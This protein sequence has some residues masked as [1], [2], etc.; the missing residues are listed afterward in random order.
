[1]NLHRIEFVGQ[2]RYCLDLTPDGSFVVS[3]RDHNFERRI[4]VN[5]SFCQSVVDKHK[6][7]FADRIRNHLDTMQRNG[8]KALVV[9]R[10]WNA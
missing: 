9:M 8:N 7:V 3:E 6:T 2:H 4:K 1:M 10:N 5:M